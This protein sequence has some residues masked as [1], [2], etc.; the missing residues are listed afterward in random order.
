MSRLAPLPTVEPSECRQPFA[1]ARRVVCDKCGKTYCEGAVVAAPTNDPDLYA[2]FGSHT[3]LMTLYCD[4]CNHL[5]RWLQPCDAQ[6]N[7]YQPPLELDLP[8]FITDAR[9]V[10]KFLAL[11]P[12]AAGVA[13]A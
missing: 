4:H 1:S 3:A 7:L 5:Q 11:H 9:L 10:N 13:Q 6:G 8:S 2:R 12:Q